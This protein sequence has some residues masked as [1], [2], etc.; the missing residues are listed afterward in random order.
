MTLSRRLVL[1]ALAA[2]PA[3]G[4][5]KAKPKGFV[6]VANG[7]LVL[8][9]K[10]YRFVGANLWYGAW[11]GSP[12]AYGDRQRLGRELDKLKALG[13]TNLR[14]LGSGE[15]SPAKVSL[16]PTF[17]GPG[18]DYDGDLLRGLDFLLAEMGKRDS[19]ARLF[20]EEKDPITIMKWKEIYELLESATDRCEDVANIIEGVVLENS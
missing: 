16:D 12:A 19:L 13:V 4:A 9:G 1:A 11:L 10:P 3:L 5:A 15:R 6:D 18:E 7:K 17:R 2:A 8:D 14:V 20:R